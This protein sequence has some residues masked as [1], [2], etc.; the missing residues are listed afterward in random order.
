MLLFYGKETG[1]VGGEN[2]ETNCD[3]LIT[4]YHFAIIKKNRMELICSHQER[5]PNAMLNLKSKTALGYI[6]CRLVCTFKTSGGICPVVDSETKVIRD[7][8]R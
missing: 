3:I 1:G 5:D 6:Y 7:E 4:M 2:E 8:F